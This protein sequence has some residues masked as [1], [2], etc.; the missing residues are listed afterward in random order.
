MNRERQPIELDR[1]M[2]DAMDEL[3]EAIT[4][5]YPGARFS[6]SHPDDEPA[7][8]ELTAVVDVDDPDDVLDLVV[9][10]VVQLQVDDGLP[11]HVVPIRTPERVAVYLD[12]QR[13]CGRRVRRRTPLLG[14]YGG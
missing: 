5:R 9:D 6:L 14:A 10:R 4:D 13:G 7:S 1:R 8:L 12:R 11:I 3:Q 2:Q